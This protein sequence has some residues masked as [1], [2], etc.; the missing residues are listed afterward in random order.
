MPC[1]RDWFINMKFFRKTPLA[2]LQVTRERTRL[3][4][5]VA[6]IAFADILMLV[7]IGFQDALFD[8]S[9]VPYQ[10]IDSDLFIVNP[11][12]ETLFSTKSFARERVLQAAAVEGVESV[13]SLYISIAQWRN[14]TARTARPIL[15]FGSDPG[16]PVFNIP[17]VDEKRDGLKQLNTVLFDRAGR[18]EFGDIGTLFE[19]QPVLETELN[20]NLIRVSGVF[21]LGASFAAEGNVITSDSTFLRVF[22]D[23]KPEDI[24]VGL[25]HLAPDADL[26]Q[27]QSNIKAALPEDVL[28]L[29]L[30]EF[31][32]REKNYW[33]SATPIGFI[34]TLGTAVGFIVGIV[35][36]YQILY[37]D[38]SDHLPEYATLKAMG[39]GDRYLIG[40]LIQESLLLA[41]L[42]F[43][44]G[45]VLTTGLY[46]LAQ[47]AT[48]LPIFM[49]LNRAITVFILTIIM[50]VGSGV[51]AM[52]KLQA[53]DPAD[54]F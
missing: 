15:V 18:P 25:I 29:T 48:M 14:P 9:A 22:P 38:V 33:A 4:V 6:G 20:N 41:V 46:A 24:D 44:P 54:I 16:I 19:Q 39:Y 37:S 3:L 1:A 52:R 26:N 30:E 47:S 36:V 42:G 32:S 17:G 40:V 13:N 31:I 12:F 50:C 2:W 43:I 8:S 34:F 51:I 35:I 5:A 49:T 7:Q 28:V 53:A 11:Q 21:A 23:R 45:A 27:V 10:T